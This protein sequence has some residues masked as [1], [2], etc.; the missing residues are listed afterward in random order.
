M[1]KELKKCNAA[2]TSTFRWAVT[3][4]TAAG[5]QLALLGFKLEVLVLLFKLFCL[6]ARVNVVTFE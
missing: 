3:V 6:R 1:L 2:V 5:W 4:I